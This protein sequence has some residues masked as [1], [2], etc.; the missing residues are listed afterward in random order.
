MSSILQKLCC[1]IL[2][3]SY[4]GASCGQAVQAQEKPPAA[5]KNAATK[6]ATQDI[7][8]LFQRGQTALQQGDLK[9]AK[10]AFRSVIDADPRSAPAYANLGVVYMREKQWKPALVELEKAKRLSPGVAGIRLNIGLAFYRQ[11]KF[12][13]AIAPFESV[14]RDSPESVQA[15]HLLGLCYFFTQDYASAAST[16]APLEPQQSNDLNFLYVL[17]ISAWKSKQ[18]DL[19]KRALTQLLQIGGD[20]P[21]FHLL[22][23]KAHLNR[24]EYDEAIKELGVAAQAAPRLPFVHFNLGLAHMKKQEFE[25]AKSEFLKD[26]EI[27]PDIS[28]NY[29]QLGLIEFNQQHLKEAEQY[30][31]HALRLDPDLTSSRYQLARVY[32]SEGEYAKALAE[33]DITKK[34]ESG[35]ASV[36]Y[37]RGQI[38]QHLGRTEEARAEMREAAQISNSARQKRQQEL[39]NGVPD[40]ELMQSGP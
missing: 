24:E 14:V 34:L 7:A 2:C 36:R 3:F 40:P 28:Y 18:P 13:D 31:R 37:L 9:Q 33:I 26:S 38:L 4:V 8:Q 30:F 5:G 20:T 17:A 1:G 21:E 35:N 39:E 27:E 6:E 23:G 29:D 16:L 19:E 32:H 15:R 10:Q 11:N 12:Q 22:M 25:L